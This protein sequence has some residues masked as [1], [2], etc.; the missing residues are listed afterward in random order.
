MTSTKT[1]DNPAN[2]VLAVPPDVA[3]R[4]LSITVKQLKRLPIP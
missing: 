1:S 2:D 4:M 3:A